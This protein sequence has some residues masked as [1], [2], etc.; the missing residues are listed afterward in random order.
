MKKLIRKEKKEM[1][2]R[3]LRK[4]KEQGRP[5]CKLFWS[6]LKGGYRNKKRNI[7]RLKSRSGKTID[8]PMEVLEELAKHWEDLGKHQTNGG[9]II[10]EMED[11]RE[12]NGLD[13][14]EKV[15][16]QQV[17]SVVRCLRR[18]KAPGPDGILNEMIV[19]GGFRVRR[20]WL[21]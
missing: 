2:K 21:N 16:W 12:D 8:E 14:C 10:A 20:P 1:R 3:T 4:I 15:T 11:R 7:L 5:S 9:R 13:M 18:G 6:D 17:L 19:Y